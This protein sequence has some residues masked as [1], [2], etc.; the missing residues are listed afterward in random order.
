VRR[1]VR[2]GAGRLAAVC[3]VAGGAAFFS[4]CTPLETPGKTDR[5]E[6]VSSSTSGGYKFDY[7]RNLAYPC[8]ISGYQ[9]FV[10]GTKVGS[11][12]TATRPLWVRMRGGGVGWFDSAGKPQPTAGNKTEEDPAGLISYLG[13]TGLTGLVKSDAAAFRLVSVSMCDHDLY[14]GGDEPDP[15]NPNTQPDGSPR[16]TNGLFATKAAI[17]F[18]KARYPT[19]KVILHGTS[20]GSAGTFG[21]AWGLQRQ[22]I[23]PAGVV[24]DSGVVNFEWE[25]ATNDQGI[26]TEKRDD[27]ALAA[28][29][30]RTQFELRDIKNEPDKL[31]KSDRLTV[32]VLHVWNRNDVNTCG[33]VQMNCPLRDGTTQTLGSAQCAHE[34]LRAEILAKGAST[35]SRDLRV[36]VS[37]TD[38]PGGCTVHVVTGKNGVNT[39]PA[40]AADYNG[41]IMTWVRARLAD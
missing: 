1:F 21:V 39:D 38:E 8:S 37:T 12:D 20:A 6:F 30:A 32:P 33:S 10:I 23:P 18:A 35:K 27:A 34:P 4:G 14:A 3:L 16:T 24:A 28:I 2:A 9:T 15:N 22:G 29:R 25:Q 41:T 40:E 31:V 5:I 36:C 17:Q 19:G 7:Y 11:D 13:N 26:C